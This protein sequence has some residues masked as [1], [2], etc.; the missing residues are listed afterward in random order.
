MQPADS[1]TTA[2]EVTI[3]D[4]HVHVRECFDVS[5]MLSA[6]VLNID[7]LAQDAAKVHPVLVLA[8][9]TGEEAF[10]RLAAHDRPLGRWRFNETDEPC[11]L[12]AER[13]DGRLLTLIN[14]R[15]WTC[16]DKLEV[17]TL[18]SDTRLA[19]G[20]PFAECIQAGL[21]VGAMVTVPWGFGKWT[22]ERRARVLDAIDR[23]GEEIV[24][25]DSAARPG[26]GRDT[27]LETG[28]LHGLA[29]LP[30]TDPLPIPNHTRRAGR[31]GLRL[32]GRPP[33]N[34]RWEWLSAQIRSSPPLGRSIGHRDGLVGA[35]ATQIRLRLSKR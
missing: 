6:A 21:E 27:V 28:R 22:G 24:L 20:M 1:A 4:G 5:T 7:R 26:R 32:D 17:L 16:Y 14:G 11:V 2:D 9:S 15:Q 18:G 31:Y 8:E 34:G 23:F 19:D 25:G 3:V 12:E 29:V 35:V 10:A 33:R 13:D 30:G